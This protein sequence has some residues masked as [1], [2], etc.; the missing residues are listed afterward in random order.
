MLPKRK[1]VSSQSN[2]LCSYADF[3]KYYYADFAKYY[4]ADFAKYY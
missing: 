1:Q 3:A 4:Y 2:L